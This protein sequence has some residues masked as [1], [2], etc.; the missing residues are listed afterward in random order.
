MNELSILQEKQE[1]TPKPSIE[2]KRSPF[3]YQNSVETGQDELGRFLLNRK[4]RV[5]LKYD[6][7]VPALEGGQI[8]SIQVVENQEVTPATVI[9]QLRNDAAKLQKEVAEKNR[10]VARVDA[11]N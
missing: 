7:D 4:C 5:Q 11:E 1:G 8:Q 3:Q 2:F 6:I 9:A 10:D